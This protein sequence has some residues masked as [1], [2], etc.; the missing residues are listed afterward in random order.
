MGRAINA[1]HQAKKRLLKLFRIST[2]GVRIMVFNA[3]GEVLLIRHTY[4][5]SDLYHLPGGGIRP[6]ERPEQAAHRETLEEVGCSISAVAR[7]SVYLSQAEGRKDTVHLF[8]AYTEDQPVADRV[9]VEEARFFPL[10][11]LPG[12]LSPATRRRILEHLGLR[13]ADGSW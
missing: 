5:R 1:L 9:E 7:V 2:R 6:W 13:T 4:G 11:A 3:S 10:Q 12:A 8:S